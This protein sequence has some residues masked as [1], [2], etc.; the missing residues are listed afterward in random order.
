MLGAAVRAASP[1]YETVPWGGVAQHEFL[2]AVLLVEDPDADAAEWLC[3]GRR[4][5]DAAART[6]E[7][8]WG[9]RTLDVDV[10]DVDQTHRDD[11]HL[12]L[13]HPRAHQRAFVLVPWLDVQPNAVLSG[14]G[15]VAQL[16]AALPD[17]ER[18]GVRRC[19]DLTVGLP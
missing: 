10:I 7:I 16:V 11:P 2:N 8:R 18:R 6:R 3:R 9:P 15:A 13:P 1:V 4:C 17:T 14:R 5:E 19:A 12:T